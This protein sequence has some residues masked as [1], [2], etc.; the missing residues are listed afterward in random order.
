MSSPAARK[1]VV[2]LVGGIGAGKS[3][4]AAVSAELGGVVIDADRIGHEALKR[5]D[6][7]AELTERWG[8]RVVDFARAVA[9]AVMA[10]ELEPVG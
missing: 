8:P 3:L 6:V 4:A 2:G 7:L 9:D 5:P 1:P 10:V